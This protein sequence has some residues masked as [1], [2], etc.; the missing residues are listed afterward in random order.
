MATTTIL[1]AVP[2]VVIAQE[3]VSSVEASGRYRFN[4]PAKSLASAIADVGAVSGWRIAYDFTFPP[5]T[6]STPLSGTMTPPQAIE[7][8]LAGTGI[9]YRV[10][11]GQ[12]IILTDPQ[13]G[14]ADTGV[15]VGAD[16]STVL[17]TITVQGQGAVTEGTNSYTADWMKT[18]NGL[19]LTQKETPQ[20]TSVVT[21]QMIEDRGMANVK[22]VMQNATGVT[23]NQYET[24][25]FE[26]YSRGF[27]IDSYQYDGVPTTLD[28][29]YQYGDG[30]L[31]TVIYDHIEIVRGATGFMQNTGEPGASVNFIRKRPT[32]EFQGYISGLAGT[33]SNYRTELDVSGPLNKAGTVRGRLVGTLQ[34]KED[35]IDLY[36]QDKNVIY[37]VIEADVTDNTT[38]TV[39]ANRQSTNS[40][41]VTWAGMPAFDSNGNLIDWA[42]GSTTGADWTN[43]DTTVVETFASVE[44]T[45]DNDWKARLSVNHLENDFSSKLLYIYGNPDL[46]TGLGTYGQATRYEGDRKQDSIAGSLNGDFDLFDRNHQFVTGFF[47]S[48]TTGNIVERTAVDGTLADVGNIF[49]WDGS[50]PE[51]DWN[52]EPSNVT[53]TEDRQI[54]IYAVG[55]FFITDPLAI[56][57]GARVNWW[58]GEK[59]SY[60]E[61]YDY[62][63]SGIVTPYVGVTYDLTDEY[64][65]YASYTNIFKPQTYQDAEGNYLDPAK[66]HN[67]EAGIK[68]SWLDGRVNASFAVFQTNQDNVAEYF[69]W[70][71]VNNRSIYRSIDGTTTRGF[72]IEVAGEVYDG[73]NVFGGYTFRSAEDEDG[74]AVNTFQPRST[75]KIGATY[76][77]PGE[78]EKLTIGGTV[79]WQSKTKN[80]AYYL[81]AGQSI[82][83]G[84]YAVVDAMARYKFDDKTSLNLNIYNIT[85][86]RYFRTMG[87]Y[88]SVFYGE[89]RTAT[90]TLKREF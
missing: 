36:K 35:T 22:D 46:D 51:P 1:V 15:A 7:R 19:V 45:F 47:A 34:T 17:E 33:Q 25:R 71:S 66:G 18:A 24:D 9:N 42:K 8:L 62:S 77:L 88:N 23:V 83:Q 89:G 81:D 26:F 73:L 3:Q 74:N 31:D 56:T 63:H 2:Q 72:E 84:S 59:V 53:D 11:G 13:R 79:R 52:T 55:R 69:D 58:K 40:D 10:A 12:S 21:R 90:L 30:S 70:D 39:G 14:I 86:E 6:R 75:L 61:N 49:A 5:N 85:D 32:S 27:Q 37:G 54:G 64:T 78:W 41:G 60:W 16:G 44:H 76:T 87:F 82:E 29:T 48:R 4:I 68:A 57:L 65:L 50:Y 67:Y 28:S 43:W 38:V 20:S 80:V